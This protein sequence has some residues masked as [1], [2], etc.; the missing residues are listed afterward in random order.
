[1]NKERLKVLISTL[2]G[3]K[4]KPN[5]KYPD[6]GFNMDYWNTSRRLHLHQRDYND[7]SGHGCGSVACIGGWASELFLKDG[8]DGKFNDILDIGH[9]NMDLLFYPKPSRDFNKVTLDEAILTLEK[10]LDTG[11]VD[12]SHVNE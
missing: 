9:D 10:L 3:L 6:L 8:L 5:E 12:W 7:N 4:E 11:E 1:M 2:E